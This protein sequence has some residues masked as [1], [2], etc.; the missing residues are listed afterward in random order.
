MLYER[1]EFQEKILV[2]IDVII[3]EKRSCNRP[4]KSKNALLI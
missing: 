3:G 2:K 1:E 4:S